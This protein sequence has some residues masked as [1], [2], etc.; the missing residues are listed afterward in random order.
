M[1]LRWAGRDKLVENERRMADEHPLE[2]ILRDAKQLADG[3]AAA[4]AAKQNSASDLEMKVRGAWAGCKSILATEVA[5]AN[6][7][8]EQHSLPERY[9]LRDIADVGAG[10]VERCNLALGIA[11][12]PPRAEYDV[13]VLAV[14][15]RVTLF[16]RASGQRHQKLSALSATDKDW[17]AALVRLYED[18]LKKG[19]EQDPQPDASDKSAVRKK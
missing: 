4:L 16:H 7:I 11:A 13:S 5:R 12:K 18:H 3:K 9:T 6:A 1:A 15:G 17:E 8:L 2:Q 19:R 14:D 10:I